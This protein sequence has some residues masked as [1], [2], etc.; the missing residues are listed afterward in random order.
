L[1]LLKLEEQQ[2]RRRLL[3]AE[4]PPVKNRFSVAAG[5]QFLEENRKENR[6]GDRA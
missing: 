1:E 3:V 4:F 2:S 6:E 5:R